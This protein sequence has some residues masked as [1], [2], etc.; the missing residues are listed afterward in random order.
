MTERYTDLQIETIVAYLDKQASIRGQEL[1]DIANQSGK[2]VENAHKLTAHYMAATVIRQL[3]QDISE[4]SIAF[5]ALQD[6]FDDVVVDYKPEPV[7]KKQ[8]KPRAKKAD[9]SKA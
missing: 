7:E 9:Q 1:A 6:S 3:Q 2:N 5:S 8:R 4:M